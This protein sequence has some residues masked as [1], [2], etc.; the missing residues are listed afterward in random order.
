MTVYTWQPSLACWA[1]I[2][3]VQTAGDRQP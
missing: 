2:A 3:V 1:W